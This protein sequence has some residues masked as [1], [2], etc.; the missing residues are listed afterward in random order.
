[1]KDEVDSQLSAMFDG[2]LPAAEC[3]LLSRRIDRDEN[4]RARWARYV[5]IGASMRYE[6]VATASAGFATR[7]SSAVAELESV[8]MAAS[9]TLPATLADRRALLSPPK[10]VWQSALAA[11]LVVAVAGL[12]IA[13]LRSAALNGVSPSLT[14]QRAEQSGNQPASVRP[15]SMAAAFSTGPSDSSWSYVTP[16]GSY[17][18][19][20]ALPLR[21]ELAD[22]IVAH[23]EY[24]SPIMR[25]D[26]LSALVSGEQGLDED[27]T[28]KAPSSGM[29]MPS[30]RTGDLDAPSVAS[31]AR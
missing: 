18:P 2:E 8:A 20:L 6:P 31:P 25:P 7:I 29:T 26:V 13:M 22:Y 9:A 3:E 17:R 1:V 23:S 10:L 24:S 15:V 30:P 27:S 28:D 21:T 12:S 16:S 4:L 14:A 11:A 19:G 5:L